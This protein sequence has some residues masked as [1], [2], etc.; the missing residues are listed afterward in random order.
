MT[1]VELGFTRNEI[2]TRVFNRKDNKD[3]QCTACMHVDDLSISSWN[4]KMTSKLSEG[5]RPKYGEIEYE[6]E[7]NNSSLCA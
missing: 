6:S 1:M 5:I 4:E 7:G 3:I 2:D